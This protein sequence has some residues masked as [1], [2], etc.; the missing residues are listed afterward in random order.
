MAGIYQRGK[1]LSGKWSQDGGV[2]RQSLATRDEARAKRGLEKRMSQM[3][4]SQRPTTS[5]VTRW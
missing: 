1:V 2:I 4:T 3:V 5:K